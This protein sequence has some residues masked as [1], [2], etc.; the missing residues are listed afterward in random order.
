MARVLV[1]HS[2]DIGVQAVKGANK[3]AIQVLISAQEGPNF[4][5]RRFIIEPGGI[6][7]KHTN[8]VE[9]EQYIL[10]GKACVSINM[11]VFTV[12]AGDVVFIPAGAAH[13]YVNNGQEDFEFLCIIPNSTDELKFIQESNNC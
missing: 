1:K 11:D 5:L 4:I 12:E 2:G 13:W 8:T 6:I 9:H 3:A 7:P 10:R